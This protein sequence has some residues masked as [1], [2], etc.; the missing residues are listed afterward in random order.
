MAQILNTGYQRA[1]KSAR[2]AITPN[3]LSFASWNVQ[4]AGE[5]LPTV[6]FES[7]STSL[8]Q[9]YDEGILGVLKCDI[10]F[11]GDWD[12]HQNFYDTVPGLFPRDDLASVSLLLS[13]ATLDNT[14]WNFPYM[15]V[16]QSTNGA[17]VR[18]KVTFD[19]S[20]FNQGKFSFPTGS[21]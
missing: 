4:V 2:V 6:N 15:R 18:G 5:D 11:G 19:V 13:R 8:N 16:R 1:A 20:G 7:Y 9:S 21:V 17:E 10:K 3:F 14:F 12:A